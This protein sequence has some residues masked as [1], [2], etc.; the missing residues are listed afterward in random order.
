MSLLL[1]KWLKAAEAERP[2][3]DLDNPAVYNPDVAL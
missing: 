1:G 3:E 2:G